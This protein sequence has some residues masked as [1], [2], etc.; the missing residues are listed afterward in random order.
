V[1]RRDRDILILGL[2][3]ILLL[4]VGYYFLLLGPLLNNLDERAQERSDKEAQLANLQQ[5][6][7]QL[8]GVRRNAPELERQLLEYSKRIPEEPEIPTLVVQIEEIARASGVTQLS[9]VPGSP[10]SPPGGG[11]YSVL[12][13]TMTFEGTYEELQEFTRRVDNLVRLVTINDVT[14]C[15]VPILDTEHSCLIEADEAAET[16]VDQ[17]VEALLQVQLEADVYF[18]P[19]DVPA[20]T[21]PVAPVIPETTPG[22][23]EGAP[24]EA[25]GAR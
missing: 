23:Q 22:A 9:I 1:D 17:G 16:T 11:N 24:G 20:G 5:D 21:A 25:T 12:P 6:V 2:L 7:A 19:S 10:G 3:V 8:E 4:V 15:R 14:Y 18:Q 13:I